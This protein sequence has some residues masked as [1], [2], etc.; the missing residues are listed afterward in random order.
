M[1]SLILGRLPY[2]RVIVAGDF[3]MQMERAT[4]VWRKY[5]LGG[6]IYEGTPTHNKGGHLDQ[7]FTN[8]QGLEAKIEDT[9][10]SDHK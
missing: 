4:A 5:G 8:I 7:I 6:T 10:L 3:N 9:D 1:L 2:S